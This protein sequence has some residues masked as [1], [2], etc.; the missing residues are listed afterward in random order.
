MIQT[1][2]MQETNQSEYEDVR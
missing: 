2:A 1:F